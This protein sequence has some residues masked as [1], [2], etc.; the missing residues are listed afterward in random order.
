MP[1]VIE[2]YELKYQI[3]EIDF[4]L[5]KMP[6]NCVVCGKPAKFCHFDVPS[7]SGSKYSKIN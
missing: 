4:Q 2:K 7:C 3:V 6:K 1:L 5:V